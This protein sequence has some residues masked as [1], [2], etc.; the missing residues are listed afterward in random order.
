M[1]LYE[2]TPNRVY[3]WQWGVY[4]E[5]LI[6]GLAWPAVARAGHRPRPRPV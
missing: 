3:A 1:E 5:E 6:H 4:L 2:D